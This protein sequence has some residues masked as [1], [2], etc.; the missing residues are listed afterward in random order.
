MFLK[1]TEPRSTGN[2]YKYSVEEKIFLKVLMREGWIAPRI[3]ELLMD[4]FDHDASLETLYYIRKTFK[5][6]DYAEKHGGEIKRSEKMVGEIH[7]IFKLTA[8][9]EIEK[10]RRMRLAVDGRLLEMVEG[11]NDQTLKDLTSLSKN[12]FDRER[13]LEGRPT[14]IT[15]S[16]KEMSD[17][18]LLEELKK[19]NAIDTSTD[20]KIEKTDRKRIESPESGRKDT[21]LETA[22]EAGGVHTE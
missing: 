11:K 13:L 10:T 3:K 12:L 14:T 17:A 21:V 2:K 4:H 1:R 8:L 22:S 9:D 15:Q 19:L 18:D 7:E 6:A 20:K 16:Y 5:L